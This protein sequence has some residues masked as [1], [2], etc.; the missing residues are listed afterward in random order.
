MTPRFTLDYGLRFTH[1]GSMFETRNYNSGFDPA[2]YKPSQAPAL[3]LPYCATGVAGNVTC[4]TANRLSYNP[5]QGAPGPGQLLRAGVRGHGR[6]G[7]ARRQ[8]ERHH[9]RHV[10]GR[11][12]GQE[13][14]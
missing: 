9:Q 12:P 14:G 11:P 10:H 2:L 3:F 4:A 7:D 5:L 8:P 6:A 13:A 1:N